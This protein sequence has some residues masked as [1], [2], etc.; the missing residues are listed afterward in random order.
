VNVAYYATPDNTQE[1]DNALG[2]ITMELLKAL[3]T[4]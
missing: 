3:I 1:L 4:G 2:L